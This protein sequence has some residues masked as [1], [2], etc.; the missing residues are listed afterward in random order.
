LLVGFDTA[1]DAAVYRVAPGLALVQTIDFITP[2][3]DDPRSF[4]KV[5]AA[6]SISD[7]Y[8]MG[9]RPITALSVACFPIGTMEAEIL[10]DILAGACEILTEAGAVLAGGHTV[11]DNELKFGLSVTGL[12]HPDHILTNACARSG[13]ILVLTKPLGTGIVTTGIKQG[14]V[15]KTEVDAVTRSMI[16]LNRDASEAAVSANAHACTDVTGFG[17]LGHLHQMARESGIAA[18]VDVCAL[19]LLPG[20]LDLARQGIAPGGSFRNAAYCAPH[21]D[22]VGVAEEY[23]LIAQDAQT[24]GGLLIAVAPSRIESLLHDLLSRQTLAAAVIGE[25]TDGIAG[26]IELR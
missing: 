25:C 9:G 1:D 5:A 18:R 20:A 10:G 13:D 11:D 22:T 21:C 7:V 3:V 16:T 26:H 12:V 4:G 24:S 14:L 6:N 2:I 15:A 19:P 23:R 17:L 8:A